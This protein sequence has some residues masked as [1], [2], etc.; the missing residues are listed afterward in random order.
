MILVAGKEDLKLRL[1]CAVGKINQNIYSFKLKL[2]IQYYYKI[3]DKLQKL[4]WLST[5]LFLLKYKRGLLILFSDD[6]SKKK[7]KSIQ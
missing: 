6:M 5:N 3:I 4:R 1:F 7:K 2:I